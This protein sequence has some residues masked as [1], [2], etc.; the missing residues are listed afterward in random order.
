MKIYLSSTVLEESLKRIRYLFD[1]FPNVV[2]GFSGGK[3]STVVLNLALQVATEKNRL[4]L[5]VLFLDQEIEWSTVIDYIRTVMNDPRV[6]PYWMQI[7]FKMDNSTSALSPWLY[8]WN[9]AAPNE[10]IRPKEEI[11]IKENTYNCDRFFGLF[12]A[13]FAKEFAGV[14][15]CYLSGVRAEESPGRTLGVTSDPTYKFITYG[16]KLNVALEHY[17]FYPIYDWSYT[18]VWKAIHEH[19]WPYSKIYDLYYQY[20]VPLGEMRVSNLT[21][22]TALRALSYLQ[23]FEPDNWSLISKRLAGVKTAGQFKKES[24]TSPE[25][26]PFM[27]STWPEYRDYLAENLLEEPSKSKL[28]KKFKSMDLKYKDINNKKTLYKTQISSILTNDYNFTK[29]SNWEKSPAV[30]TWRRYQRGDTVFFDITKN[31]YITGRT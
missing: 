11:A 9:S 28:I 29:L 20:G 2:I 24:F 23:E 15:T 6:A 27:F 18:D 17:T 19:N 14:K 4:P 22:E 1:E 10:W 3:D 30:N 21:H 7:P 8:C 16:K 26:L 25:E 5:K 13:I 31:P 12:K